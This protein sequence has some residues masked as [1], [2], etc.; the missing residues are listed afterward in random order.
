MLKKEIDPSGP[1]PELPKDRSAED[2]LRQSMKT[3]DVVAPLYEARWFD[4]WKS[5]H[6]LKV[7]TELH[8]EMQPGSSVLDLGSGV[9]DIAK[10]FSD[11]GFA[12]TCVDLSAGMLEVVRRRVPSAKL[13]Q[14]DARTLELS[15]NSFDAVVI[16]HVLPFFKGV[17][18]V[19]VLEGA[20]RVV[21]PG[22]TL[23]VSACGKDAGI[24]EWFS[25]AKQKLGEVFLNNVEVDECL[26]VISK[27]GMVIRSC[28][29]FGPPR[30]DFYILARKAG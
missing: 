12:L 1:F 7:L 30:L 8:E 24:R 22:G 18:L 28:E 9:G 2:L 25:D 14:M 20:I 3:Y 23:Y 29:S 19:Q 6:A 10:F 27:K 13:V 15:E 21:K 11:A 17:E 4:F 5:T 16:S 26:K